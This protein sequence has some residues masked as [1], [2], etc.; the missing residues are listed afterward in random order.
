ME[1][2]ANRGEISKVKIEE[3]EA[4]TKKLPGGF[5]GLPERVAPKANRKRTKVKGK[6]KKGRKY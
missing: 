1:A 3:W 6:S 4:A 5:K 2:K